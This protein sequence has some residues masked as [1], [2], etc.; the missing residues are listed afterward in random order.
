MAPIKQFKVVRIIAR[1]NVG[2]PAVHCDTLSRNL[3]D[4]GFKTTLVAGSTEPGEAS[5][6]DLFLK[7]T[8]SYELVKLPRLR[9]MLN[10]V[11]D[12]FS[13]L[14]LVAILLKEKPD[15]VHTHTAKAGFVGR[16]A[17]ILTGVPVVV[18][19]FHGHVLSGYFSKRFS[20]FITLLE[21]ILATRTTAIVTLSPQLKEILSGEFKV[22]H[23]SKFHIV[24]LGRDL[25]PF[26]SLPKKMA[27]G[28]VVLGIIGRLVPIKAHHFLLDV[29]EK[30][31][32]KTPWELQIV[33]EGTLLSELK[34]RVAK[35]EK[36]KGRIQFL[37]WRNDLANV[38]SGL[39]VSLLSSLNEGTPLCIIESF[40]AG[41][42]VLSTDVGGVRDMFSV[43]ETKESVTHCAEGFL[44]PSQDLQAYRRALTALVE[45]EAFRQRC[46]I[47]GR[48]RAMAYTE[49]ALSKRMAELYGLLL[50]PQLTCKAT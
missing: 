8:D 38:Y 44:V 6:E 19:T 23:A 31:E 43:G 47:A 25:K 9:R 40:A 4:Y 3:K 30:M 16:A 32:T 2:G 29:L 33:G 22:A 50:S 14:R 26:L 27:T 24:P 48:E 10:P 36:L 18:H 37:G 5:Y 39:D 45:D 46:S 41:V 17:A 42:P 7:Q 34:E 28:K 35:S 49:E 12:L 13:F 20:Q 11:G 21:R 1:L 15:I